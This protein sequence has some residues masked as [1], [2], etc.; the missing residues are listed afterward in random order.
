[1]IVKSV[2]SGIM[3]RNVPFFARERGRYGRK[4][5]IQ[6]YVIETDRLILRLLTAEDCEAV[7]AW[8]SD[9]DV[10]R[11]MVYPV[12]TSMDKVKDWLRS[13]RESDAEIHFGFERKTD[14]KLI[15]SGSI[16]PDAA[17]EGFW[18]FG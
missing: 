12:Y 17:R 8:V 6:T 4:T 15:G 13:L 18:G 2:I 14:H 5:R 9:E 7:Y 1:M 3:F 16:G 11:F 10:A